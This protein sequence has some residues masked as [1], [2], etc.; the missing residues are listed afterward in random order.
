ML[1][2][3]DYV[4]I[5]RQ[6]GLEVVAPY[7]LERRH[8]PPDGY[9]TLSEIH[10]KFRVQFPLHPFFVEV[11][12]YYGLTVFQIT[13]NGWAHM[14]ELFGLFVEHRMG[15]PIAAEFAWFYSVKGN[16][17]DEGFYYIAKRLVKGLQAIIK[18][19]VSLG[20]W[21]GSYFYTAEVQVK[22]TFDRGCK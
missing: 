21:K 6:Y 17:N 10:R 18:I 9:V 5:A 19:K 7:E 11:L 2:T 13:P 20:L 12:E 1:T 14:I 8:T 4:W 15:P 22:G 3:E 16:K